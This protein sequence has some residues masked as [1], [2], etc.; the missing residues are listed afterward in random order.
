[1]KKQ[2]IITVIL[3]IISLLI[4]SSTSSALVVVDKKIIKNDFNIKKQTNMNDNSFLLEGFNISGLTGNET[5][6]SISID[7]FGNI[8]AAYDFD[9]DN[10]IQWIYSTDDGN[11]WYS[12]SNSVTD[13][14]G[15]EKYPSIDY[16]GSDSRFFGTFLTPQENSNG[17]KIY[18]LEYEIGSIPIVSFWDFSKYGMS[19]MTDID[20]SCDDSK[21]EYEFGV[22]STVMDTTYETGPV[23]NGPFLLYTNPDDEDNGIVMWEEKYSGCL[24]TDIDIDHSSK[25]GYAVY[26]WFNDSI[27]KLLLWEF[28]FENTADVY[29]K[30]YVINQTS[31]LR[32][33]SVASYDDNLLIVAETDENGNKDIICKFSNNSSNDGDFDTVLVASTLDDESF[34]EISWVNGSNFVCTF[35]K[36]NDLY[37][38]ITEDG[39]ETWSTAVIVNNN[40]GSVENEYKN[41]DISEHGQI[42][43]WQDVRGLDRDVYISDLDVNKIPEENSTVHGYI[44]DDEENPLSDVKITAFSKDWNW[45][46]TI[47]TDNDGYYNFKTISGLI[48]FSATKK[49]YSVNYSEFTLEKDSI[50]YW[51]AS[52]EVSFTGL[53][54]GP[55][56][57]G[58]GIRSSIKNIGYGTAKNIVWNMTITGKR[59]IFGKTQLSGEIDSLEGGFSSGIE[60]GLLLGFGK[61]N[62]TIT[63]TSEDNLPITRS[64]E[65]FILGIWISFIKIVRNPSE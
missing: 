15:F 46:K 40:T 1:M 49:G 4:F 61:I 36:N 34:P 8:F 64:I 17:G 21:E 42:C 35:T 30:T 57:G 5:H 18:I 13:I 63:L 51:N 25:M 24:H 56:N 38:T 28:D 43:I 10:T 41:S 22:I 55:I 11:T 44:T 62:V 52:L 14:E 27:W 45:Y 58:L 33:P 12:I 39:G 48:N 19:N 16:W 2:K 65:G 47:K 7:S 50:Q 54:I 23:D 31:N 26:D 53:Q 9:V 3:L 59:R 60:S 29:N 6:P 32:Y 20:I 37:M